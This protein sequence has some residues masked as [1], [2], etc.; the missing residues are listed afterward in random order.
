MRKQITV[1]APQ[2]RVACP[3]TNN[4]PPHGNHKKQ[5]DEIQHEESIATAIHST[6]RDSNTESETGRVSIQ[7]TDATHDRFVQQCPLGVRK[8]KRRFERQPDFS[9]LGT[10]QPLHRGGTENS[11]LSDS[12]AEPSEY[13]ARSKVALRSEP[14]QDSP[15]QNFL[16]TFVFS[17]PRRVVVH[18]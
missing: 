15:W 1:S 10:L 2:R 14:N 3:C 17:R 4:V 12:K 8:N 16:P 18:I 7:T 13:E 6:V 11:R 5:H 9:L